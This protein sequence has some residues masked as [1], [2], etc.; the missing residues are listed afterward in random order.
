LNLLAHMQL[1]VI[2]YALLEDGLAYMLH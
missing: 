1:E 2:L